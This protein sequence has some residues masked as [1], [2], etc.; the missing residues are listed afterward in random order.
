M[1]IVTPKQLATRAGTLAQSLELSYHKGMLFLPRDFE[2]GQPGPCAPERRVYEAMTRDDVRRLANSQAGILF[3]NDAQLSSFELMMKQFAKQEYE[4]TDLMLLATEEGL[5]SLLPDGSLA[6]PPDTFVPNFIS[7]PVNRDLVAQQQVRD[8]M[9]NWLGNEEDVESLLYHLATALAPGYSAV[10]YLL[11]LGAGRNGKSVLLKM[12][13]DLFG[14]PNVSSIT[15]QQIA[16]ALPVCHELN[17]KLLNIVFDGKMEYIK[18]S[19]MEKTLVAGE[20]AQVRM[21]YESGTT[22]VQTNAL[23]IEALNSEPKTRDKSSALQKRLARFYFPNTFELD[24]QFE[25]EMR[26]P[27]KLGALLALLLDH[28]V[29]KDEVA[30]KLKLTDRAVELQVDQQLLNS[31]MLQFVDWLCRSDPS[32]IKKFREGNQP[33]EPLVAS[34]MA[35]RVD[36]GFSEYNSTEVLRMFRT[37]FITEVRREA[38]RRVPVLIQPQADVLALLNIIQEEEED[39]AGL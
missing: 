4:D 32:W 1:E 25:A 20:R 35:W 23:F 17:N 11:F 33:V 8:T 38:G 26:T 12:V 30:T 24:H 29:R 5:R 31:P 3:Q 18:D 34:F 13:E 39:E 28:Y 9:V 10:K 2:T 27:W 16:A 14:R 19:S 36:E 21:L 6:E 37:A 7:T 15:R 22:E